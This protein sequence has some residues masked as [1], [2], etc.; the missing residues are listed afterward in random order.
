MALVPAHGPGPSTFTRRGNGKVARLPKD[1]R[2]Q[3]NN[4]MA[5]GLPYREII[6]RLGDHGKDLNPG[7]LCEWKKRGHKEWLQQREWLEHIHSQSEF[8]TDILSGPETSGLHEAGL[9]LAAAQMFD[10]LARFAA[11]PSPQAEKFARLVNAL[12]RLTR[13]ALSFRKYHDASDLLRARRLKHLPPDREL[14]DNDRNLFLTKA[15]EL[16]RQKVL[17][18]ASSGHQALYDPPEPDSP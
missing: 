6:R 9:R 10:Q 5:D 18:D 3:I 8:S 16:F 17:R 1:A 13:E 7:H 2:D 15:E 12:S 4:L 11:D 14:T